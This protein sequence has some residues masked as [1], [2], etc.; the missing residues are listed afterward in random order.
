MG[1][2]MG[3]LGV[4]LLLFSGA[5]AFCQSGPGEDTITDEEYGI[6]RLVIEKLEGRSPVDKETLVCSGP[7]PKRML[8]EGKIPP[9]PD[10]LKD[11][12]EKNLRRYT[13]SDAFVQE[14]TRKPDGLFE[15]RKMAALSRVGFDGEKRHAMLLMGIT[16]FYPKDVMNGG[17]YVFLEKKN[18]MWTVV[19]TAVAW[20]MRL[21]KID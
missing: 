17:T 19:R 16:L 18:G 3:M 7:D 11:F 15:G 6:Y 1:K 5:A 12:N 4:F 13:L 10:T 9:A 14:M 2:F 20:S 8:F 21:G